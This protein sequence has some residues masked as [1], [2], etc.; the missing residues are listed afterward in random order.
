VKQALR[1]GPSETRNTPANAPDPLE[2]KA[3]RARLVGDETST[4]ATARD[5]S[6]PAETEPRTSEETASP[7]VWHAEG[8]PVE[9]ALAEGVRA[10]AEAMRRAPADT[11]P[12]L[13]E[14]MAV[15]AGELA[16]RRKAR[17]ARQ[18]GQVVQFERRWKR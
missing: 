8:D 15:L 5:G 17:E 3:D 12:A 2:N 14:R 10:I 13:A 6:Q 9:Q 16:S 18:P 1:G 11:L 4:I 7:S